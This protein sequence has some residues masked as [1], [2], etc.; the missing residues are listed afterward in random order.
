MGLFKEGWGAT[1]EIRDALKMPFVKAALKRKIMSAYENAQTQIIDL[2]K[3][4]RELAF[5]FEEIDIN[6]IVEA[7]QDI[8]I[9]K[10]EQA[11]TKE[12]YLKM[13]DKELPTVSTED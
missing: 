10:E 3:K 8:K 1:K 11:I 2:E 7:E 4:S 9:L 13:F 5:K 12:L 6:A